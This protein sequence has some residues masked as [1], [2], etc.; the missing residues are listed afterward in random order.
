MTH[1]SLPTRLGGLVA[2]LGL[3]SAGCTPAPSLA[4][5]EPLPVTVSKPV[6]REV[7]DF[8][9][10]TGQTQAVESVTVRPQVY[11]YLLKVNFTDGAVVK[12]G[13]VLFEIDPSTYKAEYDQTA[14]QIKLSEAQYELAKAEEARVRVLVDQRAATREELDQKI[15]NRAV[16]AQQVTKAKADADRRKVDLD[17]CTIRAEIGGRLS[18]T[19]VTRG[20]LV[21]GGE[22]VTGTELTTVVREAPTYTYFDVDER[23]YLNY[24]QKGRTG[25]GQASSDVNI[26][27]AKVP[28]W[29]GLENEPGRFPRQGI[30]DFVDNAVN[31]VTG[32]IRVRGLFDNEDDSLRPGM[33]SRVRIAAGKPYHALLVNDRAVGTE[34]GG[35][36][37]LTVGGDKKV[38]RR[39]VRTGTLQDDGLRVIEEGI[40]PGELVIVDGLQ[41]ARPGAE[42]KP[43][44]GP[45]PVT[46]GFGPAAAPQVIVNKP[47]APIPPPAPGP[48]PAK[49]NP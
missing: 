7:T 14:A 26:K 36:Y 33:N 20:N 43:Q 4:P 41:R 1:R 15:A 17:H 37:L 27:E 23:T 42:V 29:L 8:N 32:T 18:N 5:S 24:L 12:A 45:M 9:E 30:I 28:V 6:E 19:R 49:P 40:K 16:A 3:A 21:V 25:Q 35:K 44:E 34:Q 13:E 38:A 39:D 2:A 11:G 31:R 46:P 10:Y 22:G 47:T 48:A